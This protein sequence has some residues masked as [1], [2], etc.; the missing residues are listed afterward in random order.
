MKIITHAGIAHADEVL[1]IAVL[2]AA[3]ECRNAVIERRPP[4]DNELAQTNCAVVDVGGDHDEELM[5]FDHHQSY[6]G[7]E[8]AFSLVMNWLAR[9]FPG[10]QAWRQALKW[11][12]A[13]DIWDTKGPTAFAES[14]QVD[15]RVVFQSQFAPFGQLIPQMFSK[16]PNS[17]WTKELL[18]RM[19]RQLLHQVESYGASI[20]AMEGKFNT[21]TVKGLLVTEIDAEVDGGSISPINEWIAERYP[22]AAVSITRNPRGGI[23][24]LRRLDHPRVDFT[25]AEGLPGVMFTHKRGF[26]AVVEDHQYVDNVLQACIK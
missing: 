5:N 22:A 1:A 17:Q 10:L 19:G 18:F 24:L 4:S 7:G 23:S 12:T 16:D 2:M 8:C 14:L 20:A 21:R 11:S 9:K 25:L 13:L 26:L 15:S 6:G 3:L